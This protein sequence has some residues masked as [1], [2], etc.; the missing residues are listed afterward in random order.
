MYGSEYSLHPIAMSLSILPNVKLVCC[1]FKSRLWLRDVVCWQGCNDLGMSPERGRNGEQ[2]RNVEKTSVFDFAWSRH[3]E[4]PQFLSTITNVRGISLLRCPPRWSPALTRLA[5]S[6]PRIL[7]I[8]IED[9]NDPLDHSELQATLEENRHN[10]ANNTPILAGEDVIFWLCFPPESQAHATAM[11]IPSW[12]NRPGI[13]VLKTARAGPVRVNL[14]HRMRKG[15]Q[16]SWRLHGTG[17]SSTME[18]KQNPKFGHHSFVVE[19]PS[20]G[21]HQ[22]DIIFQMD[23]GSFHLRRVW[24][25]LVHRGGAGEDS[26][27]EGIDEGAET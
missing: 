8:D 11:S 12:S 24:V 4:P 19:V 22:I 2:T 23:A 20:S 6:N 16:V 21:V 13:L 9:S 3:H 14:L 15:V 18:I 1:D 5:K 17:E 27:D 10:W 25:S 26:I 7:G